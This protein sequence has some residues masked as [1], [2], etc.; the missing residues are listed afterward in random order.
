MSTH[1]D[2]VALAR[3]GDPR[4]FARLV[5]QHAG[6]VCAITTAILGDPQQGEEVGQEVFLL[7]WRGLT[8][9]SDPARFAPWLR[10]I[11]RNRAHDVRRREQRRREQPAGCALDDHPAQDPGPGEHLDAK[12]RE[13]IL[14]D[15]LEGLQPIHREVLVL[16]YRQGSSV[17]QVAEGLGLTEPT[18]RKRLSR[19]RDHLR[20]DVEAALAV[21]LQRTAPGAGFL[22]AVGAAL[23]ALAPAPAAPA[24]AAPATPAPATPTRSSA[25]PPGRPGRAPGLGWRG[26]LVAGAAGS[27]LAVAVAWSSVPDTG[28]RR[29]PRPAQTRAGQATLAA[30]PPSTSAL[31]RRGAVEPTP[32]GE[33]SIVKVYLGD[34]PLRG[35]PQIL[36][37]FSANAFFPALDEAPFPRSEE[38][39][40]VL[41][42]VH[43][44]PHA[45]VDAA[46]L[47]ATRVWRSD[48]LPADPWA[49]LITLEVEWSHAIEAGLD[50]PAPPARP[51]ARA[52]RRGSVREPWHLTRLLRLTRDA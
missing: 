46:W 36:S 44:T 10:R 31:T 30:L 15:S 17:R 9:L 29:A 38:V 41:Q 23:A 47:E 11:A 22:V 3:H 26:L 43:E 12:R 35:Q 16:F 48:V 28:A 18:V 50:Q 33:P 42:H 8:G 19:A 25:R 45:R 37:F 51:R 1:T 27:L 4:A 52:Q 24:T 40:R 2:D 39:Q 13:A 32:S 6:T 49:A 7:A 21:H 20:S 34:Q 5:Q 14:S